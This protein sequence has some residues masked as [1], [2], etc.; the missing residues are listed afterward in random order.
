MAEK[1][2]AASK[3]AQLY[4]D[5]IKRSSQ[6]RSTSLKSWIAALSV[7]NGAGLIGVFSVAQKGEAPGLLYLL[8]PSAWFFLFGLAAASACAFGQIAF[9]T[10]DEEYWRLS[11]ANRILQES[12]LP[13]QKS[14]KE[15]DEIDAVGQ[16]WATASGYAGIISSLAFLIGVG[17]PLA[18]VTHRAI[19]SSL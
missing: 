6:D 10:K 14:E 8:L 9:H 19:F 16:R 4:A 7:G 13:P 18:R 15:L 1:P 2:E 12:N 11:D 3:L 17:L 5:E